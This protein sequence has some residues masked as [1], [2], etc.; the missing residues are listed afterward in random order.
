MTKVSKKSNH[1]ETEDTPT[2]TDYRRAESD[3][4]FL[5]IGEGAILTN[6]DGNV[7]RINDEALRILGYSAEEVIGKW[8]PET[9]VAEDEHGN[10]IPNFDRPITQ[11]FMT[12]KTVF[13]KIFYRRKDG[14]RVAVAL[15]VSPVLINNT[16]IGAIEVFR[17][18]T[19]E[20]RLDKAR[21]EFIA[22]ASHQLRTPATAV[23]QYTGMLQQGY[24]GE[25]TEKQK[26]MVDTIYRSNERQIT[27]INELLRIAQLDAGQVQLDKH[28]TDMLRMIREIVN[29]QQDVFESRS[30]EVVIECSKKTIQAAV[31][32]AHMRM[33]LENIVDNA[34]KYTPHGKKITISFEDSPDEVRVI[35]RDQGVG[36]DPKELDQIF[37]KFVRLDNP[38]S[39]EVGGT[40]LGL[41]WVKK[42][43]DLHG[44]SLEVK[45]TR[46]KG[47]SF[48]VKLPIEW[49]E[50]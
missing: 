3:A 1:T 20:M 26:G 16:P 32:P 48:I 23:K 40:G 7:S 36:M 10:V 12:G 6:A 39:T 35:V 5:S 13:R 43:I 4:L 9:V 33:A 49:S 44:A 25:L 42:I 31:D 41:Y 11:V 37:Q 17:D 30:Q 27:I 28:K 50:A 29:E 8:Y 22:L 46:G 14:T 2:R 34:S 45:S 19:D 24:A 38:L 21:D 15:T 47:S 18:I